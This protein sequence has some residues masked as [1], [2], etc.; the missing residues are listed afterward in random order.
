M[1]LDVAA[2]LPSAFAAVTTTLSEEPTSA[3]VAVYFV[4]VAPAIGV[5]PLVSVQ[6]CHW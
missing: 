2:V 5:Q 3:V 6:R 4:V 1:P